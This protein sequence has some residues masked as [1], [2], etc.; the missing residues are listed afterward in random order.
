MKKVSTTTA[1]LLRKTHTNGLCGFKR[2]FGNV[3]HTSY[4]CAFKH[5]KRRTTVNCGVR[6]LL[7]QA[8]SGSKLAPAKIGADD[9]MLI[10]TNVML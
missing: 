5:M 1:L 7:N 4:M 6:A 9:I 10:Y 8:C 3:T 2:V